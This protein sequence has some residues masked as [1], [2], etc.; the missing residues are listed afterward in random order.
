MV[1]RESANRL[2]LEP[3]EIEKNLVYRSLR[4]I[5]VPGIKPKD[6][7]LLNSIIDDLFPQT[8]LNNINYEWLRDSF[9]Q[10]CNKC[11]YESVDLLYKKLCEV[12]EMTVY[13]KGIVLMGNPYTGKSFVLKTLAAAVAAKNHMN[14]NEIDIGMSVLIDGIDASVYCLLCVVHLYLRIH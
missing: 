4:D 14:V 6:L 10:N 11:G 9:E 2:L 13:R 3:E 7:P 1:L 5:I 12:Y 8:S